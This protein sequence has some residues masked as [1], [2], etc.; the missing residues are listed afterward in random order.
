ME[1]ISKDEP[2]RL[3]KGRGIPITGTKPIVI[4]IL[5]KKWTKIIPAIP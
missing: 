5:I 2:P 4:P 1:K 3:I